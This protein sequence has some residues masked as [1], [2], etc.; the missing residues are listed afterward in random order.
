MSRR[1]PLPPPPPAGRKRTVLER[2]RDA[3]YATMQE[4]GSKRFSFR[5]GRD[6]VKMTL[7][8]LRKI[9]RPIKVATAGSY[10]DAAGAKRALERMGYASVSEAMDAHFERIPFS[11][12]LIG[13]VVLADVGDGEFSEIGGLGIWM[14]DGTVFCYHEDAERPVSVVLMETPVATWGVL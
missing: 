13:D 9:G 3:T 8:H 11:R 5:L 14:G 2:R 4:F 10:R 6:C 1:I 12:V 7:F